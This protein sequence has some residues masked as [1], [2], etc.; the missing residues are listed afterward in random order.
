ME[1]AAN[2]SHLETVNGV[3]LGMARAVEDREG[4]GPFDVL[5]ILMHGDSAF[6]GQGIVAEATQ[7]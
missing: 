3:V 4:A 2:P 7:Q 6:A 1:L 5:P